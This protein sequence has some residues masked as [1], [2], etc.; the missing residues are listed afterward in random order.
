MAMVVYGKDKCGSLKFNG[1]AFTASLLGGGEAQGAVDKNLGELAKKAGEAASK[2]IK[3][4]KDAGKTVLVLPNTAGK[5]YFVHY[6]KI[7]E[8]F[9]GLPSDAGNLL[10]VVVW[11]TDS[12]FEGKVPCDK[13]FTTRIMGKEVQ[14][15]KFYNVTYPPAICLIHEIGHAR[16]VADDDVQFKKWLDGGSIEDLEKDNIAR[17]EAPVV[18]KYGLKARSEYQAS[19]GH[20][21]VKSKIAPG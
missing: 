6:S 18:K 7:G 3:A 21:M 8:A 19:L 9:E 20:M 10:G 1:Q 14:I 17:H 16:Q 5:N 11:D 15:S 4:V 12:S 13:V 2:T